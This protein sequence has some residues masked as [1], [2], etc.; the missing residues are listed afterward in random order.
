LFALPDLRRYASVKFDAAS[1][2]TTP[3]DYES[4]QGSFEKRQEV[5]MAG[6]LDGLVRILD[7]SER[8]P[9]AAIAG[10]VLAD[11]GAE[12]IRVEPEGGDPVRALA[13][14]RVWL[15]G[16]K[17]V[18]VGPV[19]VQNGQ[20]QTLRDSADVIIDTAQPWRQKPR[21]LL[22]RRANEQNPHSALG[23]ATASS[24][25]SSGQAL[26][27]DRAGEGQIIAVLTA[28]PRT[29][30]ELAVADNGTS[31]PVCGELIEAQ[32]GMQHF[33]A[34]VRE[35]GPA[36][37]GWPHAI[38]GAAWLL[39]IGILGALLERDRIGIGQTVTT[40]L[41]DGIAIL[42]NARWLGGDNLGP[43]LL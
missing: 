41:L 36:F 21:E 40:S 8:S 33:Q 3:P 16:Q 37:L 25:H 27:L 15:R 9:A 31:Y 5:R 10:M 43:P 22:D 13:A 4:S 42:S 34:G 32:Y 12:V 28:Y 18:T 17:S 39:Q 19:Q 1:G 35:G 30:G 2:L 20:W 14:S 6:P 38:Y 11:L 23:R 7:L 24:P 26:P 29:V